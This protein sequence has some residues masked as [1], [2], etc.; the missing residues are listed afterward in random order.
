M[1]H[2]R[3]EMGLHIE[4]CKEFGVSKEE[5]EASEESQGNN[6][7]HLF[8]DRAKTHSSMHSIYKVSP[9]GISQN[10]TQIL[11]SHRYVLDIGQSQ[12]WL[13]LQM[14]QAP[15]LIGYGEIAKRLHADPKTKRDGNLY[16]KWIENYVADD[17][18]E[19]IQVGSGE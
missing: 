10:D 2:I 4:Y 15:C 19:A 13:A 3:H 11:N 18:D 5:I 12:D 1:A 9:L 14:A 7:S 6:S 17:Y 16:W 8:I